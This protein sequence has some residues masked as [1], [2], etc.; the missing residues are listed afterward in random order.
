M[1]TQQVSALHNR[2]ALAL[3]CLLGLS[4][5]ANPVFAALIAYDGINYATGTSLA[6]QSGGGSYGFGGPWELGGLGTPQHQVGNLSLSHPT[7]TLGTSGHRGVVL[8]ES[9]SGFTTARRTLS[10]QLGTP[11]TTRYLSIVLQPEGQLGEGD[12]GGYF[13][14]ELVSTGTN[15]FAGKPSIDEYVLED[16]GGSEQYSTGVA[17]IAGEPILLVLRADF[18]S[19]NDMF[20]LYVNPPPGQSEPLTPDAIKADS[21]VGVVMGVGLFSS[22]VFSFDEIRVGE[23]FADVTPI[24]EPSSLWLLGGLLAGLLQAT[25]QP[26]MKNRVATAYPMLANDSIALNRR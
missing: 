26:T 21:D 2:I 14:L 10:Q 15:L 5:G 13:G 17:A 7:A 18:A 24:P 12:A 25:R 19:G 23:T 6:A 4:V 3:G 22:G 20:Q 16:I 1:N 8:S 9:P 11:G